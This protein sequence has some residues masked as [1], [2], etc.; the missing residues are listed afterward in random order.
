MFEYFEEGSCLT[1]SS[2]GGYK[3]FWQQGLNDKYLPVFLQ[4]A[5]YDTYYA[6]KIMN[7]ITILNYFDPYLKG[8][9]GSEILLDPYTYDYMQPGMV[10]NKGLWKLYNGTYNTD[11][12][13][14]KSMGFLDD[15][16]EGGKPFFLGMAPIAPHGDVTLDIASGELVKGP[17]VS[18]PRHENMFSDAK[19][20]REA[21]FNPEEASGASWV[22]SLGQ[23]SDEEVEY[24]DEWYCLRLRALQAVDDMVGELFAKLEAANLFDNTYIIFTSDNGF[25]IS[26]H[27][28]SPGKTCGYEEDI[29]V[30]FIVRGPGIS[31]GDTFAEAVSSHV[32]LLPTIFELAGIEQRSDFDGR[33]IALTEEEF[34]SQTMPKVEHANVEMWRDNNASFKAVSALEE[35]GAHN[36]YKSVRLIGQDYSL[37]YSVW[38]TNEHELYDM[39]VSRPGF[40]QYYAL[41]E[42]RD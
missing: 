4:D 10:R 42:T 31:Q 13:A 25:H 28:L 3:K 2:S 26:Q 19:V 34:R 6:G 5:G 32:D 1:L 29:N 41:L 12:V 15:A 8:W 23:L 37:Y 24:G 16:I 35:S 33:P 40:I 11:L 36:T 18:A 9:T 38:C 7:E 39:S 27:R 22:K 14:E 21:N 20:P 17:P 30:P